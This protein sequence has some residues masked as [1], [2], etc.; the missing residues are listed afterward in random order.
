MVAPAHLAEGAVR[1]DVETELNSD[2]VIQQTRVL[3]EEEGIEAL[4]ICFLHSYMEPT[5]EREAVNLIEKT[6]PD[7]YVSGSSDVYPNMREFE[8][9]T[10]TVINAYTRPMADRYLQ[11]LERELESL[12]FN[13]QL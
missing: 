6:F 2:E 5:H 7:L 8:R 12:G 11:K 13:G 1:G 4:A 10:T 3:I 9:W